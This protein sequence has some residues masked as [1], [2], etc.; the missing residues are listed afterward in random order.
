MHSL[1]SHYMTFRFY[2]VSKWGK[3][4]ILEKRTHNLIYVLERSLKGV[5][6]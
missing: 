1:L 5:E 4:R 6:R 2:S 3:L